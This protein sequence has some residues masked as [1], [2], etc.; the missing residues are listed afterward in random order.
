MDEILRAASVDAVL[1]TTRHNVQYFLGGY[2]YFFFANM[3]AIGISR[4]LP[5][6]GYVAE[7]P[8]EAFYIGCG[9][10]A[11]GTDVFNFWIKDVQHVSW[12]SK[13][14][15]RAAAEALKKRGLAAATI[16]VEKAFLPADAM[17]VLRSELP[18]AEFVDAQLLLEQLRAVKS[19]GEL[20]L[21]R[22]ASNG[23]IDSMLATFASVS[24]GMSKH[25]IVER[26]RR[27]QTNRGL[28]FDYCL[29]AAG[30]ESESRAFVRTLATW[31]CPVAGQRRHVPG[32]HR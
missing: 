2:R 19:E 1:A 8:D 14:S 17:D 12:S 24:P 5:V 32:V 25:E 26:F 18:G 4:Y 15:G 21:V 13:D 10:E 31:H 29:I 16:A 20:E 9:N 23:I 28:V 11:W 22:L 3:D 7:R 6:L 30:P 27:E